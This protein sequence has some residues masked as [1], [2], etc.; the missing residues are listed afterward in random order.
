MFYRKGASNGKPDTFSRHPEYYPEKGGGGD[1][2]RQ[3]VLSEKHFDTMSVI[4]IG[5]ERM[6]FCYSA[7]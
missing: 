1:Q 4:S 6:V 2:Q 3:T 5:R 7:V